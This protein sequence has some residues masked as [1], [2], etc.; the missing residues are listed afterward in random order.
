MSFTIS[1]FRHELQVDT[2]PLHERV[3]QLSQ[4][5]LAE[6]EAAVGNDG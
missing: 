4:V 5:I 3:T 2:V 1:A 6:L